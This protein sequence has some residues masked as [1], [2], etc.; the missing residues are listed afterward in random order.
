MLD[1]R[2]PSRPRRLLTLLA[3]MAAVAIVGA[4]VGLSRAFR[5]VSESA[6]ATFQ[7]GQGA[8][9]QAEAAR[10]GISLG[11]IQAVAAG[12]DVSA[13]P[14]GDGNDAWLTAQLAR[15]D[16]LVQDM[17]LLVQGADGTVEATTDARFV[18]LAHLHHTSAG[19]DH[20]APCEVCVESGYIAMAGPADDRGCRVVVFFPAGRL[21]FLM[22]D[23]PG[24]LVDET[25]RIV[26]HHDPWQTG[27]RPFDAERDDPALTA[28]LSRMAAGETGHG[29]YTWVVPETG[30]AVE[31]LAS[32]APVPGA[33]PGWSLATSSDADVALVDFRHALESL[34]L[35]AVLVGVAASTLFG[36]VLLLQR[37]A[38]REREAIVQERVVMAQSAAHSDRLALI[39]T[40]TAGVA[41]D[42]RGPLT[43]LRINLHL[44]DEIDDP[45]ELREIR[46]DL[47]LAV[48]QLTRLSADLTRFSRSE[49]DELG[50]CA[51]EEA[52]DTA[53]R[54]LAPQLRGGTEVEVTLPPL[55]LVGIEGQRLSQVFMNLLHNASFVASRVRVEG[56]RQGAVVWL[57]VE[58]DGPGVADGLAATLF[59]PFVT[60]RKAGEGT[61]LG[62]YLCRRFVEERGGRIAVDRGPLGGARFRIEVPAVD[63]LVMEA[64]R[65]ERA[66]ATQPVSATSPVAA[67]S[68]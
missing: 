64:P 26:A 41:H 56:G 33:P 45:D 8:A 40:M 13:M 34:G 14:G 67:A 54:I 37:G 2:P 57:T 60:S 58:D 61:G 1:A 9:I 66:A 19:A 20:V 17:E 59:D 38:Q 3:V 5:G 48:D 62:L 47:D 21:S 35:A 28:M 31:R 46:R 7:S 10:T 53:L 25:G 16:G 24:W 15:Y 52:L 63:G 43:T 36:L 39:G 51:P 6:V 42:L 4:V 18:E 55:P 50:T 30:E 23:P 49:S 22:Q 65:A 11:F 29:R 27:T 68:A 32:F 12:I 44:L